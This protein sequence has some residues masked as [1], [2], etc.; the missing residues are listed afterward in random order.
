MGAGSRAV[1]DLAD[2]GRRARHRLDA[3]RVRQAVQRY[4]HRLRVHRS[5]AR[6]A[7][8]PPSAPA[9]TTFAAISLAG[10]G[11]ALIGGLW[12]RAFFKSHM[13]IS[14]DWWVWALIIAVLMYWRTH[15]VCRSRCRAQ[16][17]LVVLSIIPFLVLF[18]K[19][20]IDGG[21][22]GNSLKSFNPGNIAEGG[23]VFKGLLFAILMFIGFELAAALGR[24]DQGSTPVDPHR[25]G[26]DGADRRCVLPDHPV[27]ARSRRHSRCLRLRAD[28]RS[29]SESVLRGV[30]RPG[31]P[32]RHPRRRHR[33]RACRARVA[34]S[35]CAR[36]GLLPRRSPR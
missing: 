4:R 24:G 6:Q 3:Q 25:G 21:P 22:E 5:L 28:G 14:M 23:S 26:G 16:L 18:I 27:H 20:L 30:D 10:P 17:V 13:D 31:H 34:C 32:S 19:V 33:V 29:L 7:Q 2:D 35:L 8:R 12:A 1:R 15:W 9:S 36:D 11:I